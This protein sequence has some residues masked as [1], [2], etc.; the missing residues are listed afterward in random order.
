MVIDVHA[1]YYPRAYVERIGRPELPVP[2]SAPLGEQGMAE[3]LQL[4]DR[5]G[6]DAQVL[7]VSQAQ[8]YLAES[9]DAQEAAVLGNDLFCEV[10]R[11]HRGR[12]YVFAALPLPH[13]EAALA[14]IERAFTQPEVVG[15]TIGCSIGTYQID[16]PRFEPVWQALNA[17]KTTV[18]L[19]PMGH[20][21]L[22]WLADY[23]LAWQV[24]AP[25]EDTVAALR[26][27]AS[28]IVRRYP[29]IRFIVPHLGG[30]IPFLWER[31]LGQSRS[32]SVAEDLKRLY[33]DTV[34]RSV[35]SATCACQTLGADRLLFGT[36]YPYCNEAAFERHYQFLDE[37]GLDQA[38]VRQIRGDLAARILGIA[39]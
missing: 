3:R 29:E 11:Q 19:H 37:L 7:S 25:F 6:I 18:F 1:H 34:S 28:G 17:R 22:P 36:D 31:I 16:D 38:T 12:F 14:E 8:P 23:N 5:V 15:V 21:N 4:M 32:P 27:V 30:T 24:G 39:R 2:A 9:S 33:Y 26:L 20:E 13:V 10:A 35:R